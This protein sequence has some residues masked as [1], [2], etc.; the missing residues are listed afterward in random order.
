VDELI[1]VF[2]PDKPRSIDVHRGKR[3]R[4]QQLVD[5]RA[6]DV[7]L[8]RNLRDAVKPFGCHVHYLLDR[9]GWLIPQKASTDLLV[10][11]WIEDSQEAVGWDGLAIHRHPTRAEPDHRLVL[12]VNLGG[13]TG[14]TSKTVSPERAHQDPPAG[15]IA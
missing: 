3:A 11:T 2:G 7:E 10:L 15:R 13:G 5:F 1:E 9:S 8:L 4:L 14:S 12:T 6:A